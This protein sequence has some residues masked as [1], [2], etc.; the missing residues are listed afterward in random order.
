MMHLWLQ[1]LLNRECCWLQ[2]KHCTSAF[3]DM[4]GCR[5]QTAARHWRE[6]TPLLSD[7]ACMPGFKKP[8]QLSFERAQDAREWAHDMRPAC[9]CCT[10]SGEG[11]TLHAAMVV[12]E[13]VA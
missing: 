5:L 11:L 9:A 4:A 13:A 7:P 3:G 2:C 10:G 8:P 6:Q 12:E 1:Q